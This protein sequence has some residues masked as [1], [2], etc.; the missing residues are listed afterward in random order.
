VSDSYP[1]EKHPGPDIDQTIS[2]S[3][4]AEE[5]VEMRLLLKLCAFMAGY[6]E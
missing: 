1:E 3:D 6:I 2:Y 4:E 5:R